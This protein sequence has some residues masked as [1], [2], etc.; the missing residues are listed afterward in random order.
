MSPRTWSLDDQSEVVEIFKQV[1]A[2]VE[3]HFVYAK[4]SK[5][6]DV[7][8][9]N[10]RRHGGAY[11]AKDEVYPSPD[12]FSRL[13]EL[14][15][16]EFLRDHIDTVVGIGPIANV[17]AHY[18]AGSIYR[19][20]SRPCFAIAAE[21]RP[22]VKT[23]HFMGERLV[24]RPSFQKFIDSTQRVLLVEDIVNSGG[25]VIELRELVE[26]LG[27]EDLAGVAALWSRNG[28]TAEDLGV[29][30][31]FSL[32]DKQYPA[33]NREDCELCP[34]VPVDIDYGHGSDFLELGY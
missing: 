12:Q 34:D 17:L 30:Q 6:G 9:D 14:I 28:K 1:G 5:P 26:Q 20:T 11:V 33:W 16:N 29:E 25:S 8:P 18:V 31:F 4:G 15:A 24:I 19:Q 7:G 23:G 27:G 22:I 3:G 10:P 2:I 13:A 32:C 21:K